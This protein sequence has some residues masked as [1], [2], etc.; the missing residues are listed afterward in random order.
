MDSNFLS[1]DP[2]Q[3]SETNVC[4]S[5]SNFNKSKSKRTLSIEITTSLLSD[6]RYY[7]LVNSLNDEQRPSNIEGTT[8]YTVFALPVKDKSQV[9]KL[10][11]SAERLDSRRTFYQNLKIM[12][13]KF[14]CFDQVHLMI[15]HK[16][17]PVPFAGISILAVGDLL[18]LNPVGDKLLSNITEIFCSKSLWEDH[19]QLHQLTKIVHQQSDPDFAQILSRI[20]IGNLLPEDYVNH[21][22]LKNTDTSEVP[23]YPMHLFLTNAQAQKHNNEKLCQ[24]NVPIVT[25]HACDT[26]KDIQTQ[27][28]SLSVTSTNIHEKGGLAKGLFIAIGYR[29]M[30]TNNTDIADKLVNCATGTW[31]HMT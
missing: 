27:S 17:P 10:K 16:K 5:A 18:Q 11:T 3:L 29:W 9:S 25:I 19:F 6:D 14:L 15:Y 24:F 30:H 7:D 4:T 13:M 23:N 12:I 28:S 2:I 21:L 22:K 26:K 20:R 1:K 8:L 31:L